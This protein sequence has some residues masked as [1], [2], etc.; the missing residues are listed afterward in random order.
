MGYLLNEFVTN[1]EKTVA[2]RFHQAM[3]HRTMTF[4]IGMIVMLSTIFLCSAQKL[5]KP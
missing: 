2:A 5:I 4:I 1:W 3:L